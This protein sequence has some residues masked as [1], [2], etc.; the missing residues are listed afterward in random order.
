MVKVVVDAMGGDEPPST[1]LEGIA[2][3]LEADKEL[4]VV[5]A[6]D[7]DVVEPFCRDHE[8]TEPLVTTEVIAMDEHPAQAVRAK[9][10]SSIV[11]GCKAVAAGDADAFFS[12]GSTGAILTAATLYVKRLKGVTRPCL[13]A[14]LPGVEG[15]QTVVGDLGANADCRP[16][17]I[18]Q[19]AEMCGVLAKVE[20]GCQHEPKVGLLSNGTEDTKGSEQSQAFF[21]ALTEAAEQ[22]AVAFAGNCEGKDLLC[23]DYDAIVCDGF[24]GNVALKSMEGTAKYISIQLKAAAKRSPV[25]AI[26]AL[27][28]KGEF[29]KIAEDLSGDK[30]GGAAL[31]GLRA[32][33]LVGHGHTSPM[34]VKNGTLAAVRCVAERLCDQVAAACAPVGTE[35]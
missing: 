15:H 20:A 21:K 13:A 2:Q 18:V 6:G 32:P 27:M 31:L 5:V 35:Q 33:V 19:F 29:T 14:V 30:H 17:M 34:A 23:G 25:N 3:A 28:I 4:T 12:A 11:R 10:D 26:G 24:T 22:G 1:V 8:R 7:A 9:K 16:E